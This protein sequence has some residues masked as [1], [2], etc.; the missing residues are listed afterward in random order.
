MR[1]AFVE[2]GLRID[3][4]AEAFVVNASR[5]QHVVEV[6]EPALAAGRTVLCDRFALATLAYQGYGRGV[7]LDALRALATIAT[8]GRE[9]DVTL[10]VDIPV[11][12]SRERVLSRS[13]AEGTVVDRLEREGAAFHERVR[14]GY[15]ALAQSDARTLVLDGTL[16]PA[17]LLEAAWDA[18][19]P[20]LS[21]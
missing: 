18:L 2:P 12:V 13:R 11:D 15:L 4:M 20:K 3:P 21:P 19:A 9:P 16:S 14:E 8:R 17:D 1:A 5:A 7:D 6:I 10:L